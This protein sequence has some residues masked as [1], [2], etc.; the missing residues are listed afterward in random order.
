M[1]KQRTEEE[2]REKYR[3]K[4]L[5]VY[6]C[7]LKELPLWTHYKLTCD[8]QREL[9]IARIAEYTRVTEDEI[10]EVVLKQGGKDWITKTRDSNYKP[11]AK[12]YWYVD[13]EGR[14]NLKQL[15]ED[16]DVKEWF[17]S[18]DFTEDYSKYEVEPDEIVVEETKQS[19]FYQRIFEMANDGISNGKIAKA[20]STKEM[21]IT[22]Q[23]IGLMRNSVG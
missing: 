22:R 14:E 7:Y 13:I 11:K 1:S 6:R 8:K 2:L 3:N 15:V 20:V 18:A 9:I 19:E 4:P 10:E 17:Y 23:A 16:L 12:I 21:S 5:K